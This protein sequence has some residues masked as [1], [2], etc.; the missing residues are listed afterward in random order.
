MKEMNYYDGFEPEPEIKFVLDSVDQPSVLRMWVG[1]F[2]EIMK[3]IPPVNSEWLGIAYEYNMEEGWYEESPWII[4]ELHILKSQL[5]IIKD[6][7]TDVTIS[8]I[9]ID[10]LTIIDNAVQLKSKIYI[11]YE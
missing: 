3:M 2:D 6:S 5:E 9:C 8:S 1:Y 11:I 4:P 7:V 10:L